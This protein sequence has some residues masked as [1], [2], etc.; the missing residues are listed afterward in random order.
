MEQISF[1]TNS[2]AKIQGARHTARFDV[3]VMYQRWIDVPAERE[4]LTKD[5][6]KI[7]KEQAN[8][9]RQLSNEQFLA[10]APAKVVEGLKARAEEL[11][12]LRE[13]TVA[14]LKELT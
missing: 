7:E 2:L 10:K 9:Q 12:V 6:E 13:K 14:K 8:G 4:R 3:H 11:R 5:L 1:A